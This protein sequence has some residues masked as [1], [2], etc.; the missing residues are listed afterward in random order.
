[1]ARMVFPGMCLFAL[2]IGVPDV[3]AQSSWQ[4][5]VSSTQAHPLLG[6]WRVVETTPPP[7][8]SAASDAGSTVY[9]VITA[10]QYSVIATNQLMPAWTDAV[11]ASADELRS[12]GYTRL[13]SGT[14]RLHGGSQ[15]AL[16]RIAAGDSEA[17]VWVNL[18]YK[19]D[20]DSLTLRERSR[21]ITKLV[22][23][24]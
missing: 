14:Y 9:L 21:R 10:Q 4:A 16:Y 18:L 8:G 1:M 11:Y 23:V 7:E 15:L 13:Y 20:G 3:A 2:A 19:V 24:E 12:L 5:G 17:E 22:K 6:V